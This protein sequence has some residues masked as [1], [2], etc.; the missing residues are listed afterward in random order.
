[1]PGI[2]SHQAVTNLIWPLSVELLF[3]ARHRG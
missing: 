3:M 1:M 2:D